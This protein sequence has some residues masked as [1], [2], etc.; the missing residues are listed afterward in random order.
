MYII[1]FIFEFINEVFFSVLFLALFA[2]QLVLKYKHWSG[3]LPGGDFPI[4][5]IIAFAFEF[6]NNV[7]LILFHALFVHR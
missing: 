4:V 1:A 6:I 5:Y 7:F 3:W 2:H